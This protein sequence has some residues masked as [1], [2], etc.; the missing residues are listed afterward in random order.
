MRDEAAVNVVVVGSRDVWELD[1]TLRGLRWSDLSLAR[2]K[3]LLVNNARG[4]NATASVLDAARRHC[5]AHPD[6]VLHVYDSW[7]P[8]GDTCGRGAALF[9]VFARFPADA[10]VKLDDDM[11]PLVRDWF[12]RLVGGCRDRRQEL[13]VALCNMNGTGAKRFYEHL[14]V[15]WSRPGEKIEYGDV[16]G[17]V[18]VWKESLARLP[19]LFGWQERGLGH[20]ILSRSQNYLVNP[21]VAYL[22]RRW[23][24]RRALADWDVVGEDERTF[25]S[26]LPEDGDE[27]LLDHG[28][29]F[30]HWGYTPARERLLS[31]RDRL[32]VALRAHWEG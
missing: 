32:S 12:P 19:A 20:E 17:Q 13:G 15:P 4:D 11:F 1:L 27:F 14:G 28:S 22:S 30:L 7:P 3:V 9:D 23:I 6:W 2:T 26:H 10:W 24:D 21:N 31:E 8:R 25:N 16:E 18:A 29:L 5:L